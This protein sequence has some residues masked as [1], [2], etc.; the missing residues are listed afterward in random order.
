MKKLLI[1]FL[2]ITSI[3]LPI[4]PAIAAPIDPD[5]EDERLRY[6]TMTAAGDWDPAISPGYFVT[7]STYVPNCMQTL[8]QADGNWDRDM[9]KVGAGLLPENTRWKNWHPVLATNWT[10][11]YWPE[12]RNAIGIVNRGGV[13]SVTYTLREGVKFH[14]GSDWNATVAK[15]NLDRLLIISG[16]LSGRGDTR[17]KDNYW[18]KETDWEDMYT[19]SWNMSNRY[20]DVGWYFDGTTNWTNP[21]ETEVQGKFPHFET[22]IIE[23]KQSGGKIKIT[24]NLWNHYVTTNTGLLQYM[25]MH[26][27]KD[28]Y[29]T[30]IYGWGGDWNTGVGG[31]PPMMVGTGPFKY[32]GHS[33][34]TSPAGGTLIKN[35][36][37]W[38]KTALEDRG[39]FDLEY[40]DVLSWP[41]DQLGIESRNTAMLTHSVDLALDLF[42]WPLDYTDMINEPNINYYEYLEPIDYIT[43]LTL[44]CINET[45][46]SYTAND[47]RNPTGFNY[48]HGGVASIESI[49][50]DRPDGV[51]RALRKAMAYAF[52]YDTY[53]SVVMEGRAVRAGGVIGKG[54]IYYNDTLTLPEYNLTYA[55]QVLLNAEPDVFTWRQVANFSALCAARGL[56]ELSTNADWQWVADN[57]PLFELNLYWDDFFTPLKNLLQTNLRDI[58]IALT[59]PSGTTNFIPT[60]MWDKVSTYWLGTFPVW[61]AHAWPL[62]WNIPA[63]ICE[64]WIEANYYDPNDG[65]WRLN[66]WAPLIDPT[67]EWFPW[68]NLHFSYD[69]DIDNWLNRVFTSNTSTIAKML[70]K[71]ADK[72]QNEL[73]SML[74]IAQHKTGLAYWNEWEWGNWT[75]SFSFSRIRKIAPPAGEPIS[76][77]PMIVTVSVSAIALLST[78]YVMMR[79][80]K[81]K[82]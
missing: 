57:D 35:D 51:P 31:G 67:W 18:T 63:T 76:S 58:G 5:G 21:A 69:T 49:F 33:E 10:V 73:Y 79:R 74:Y 72:C 29:D 66:P 27:Y 7:S 11:E 13:K 24:W 25:S 68:F 14:D 32:G 6:A 53:I 22:E 78:I 4:I 50:G 1:C 56:T 26:T 16:N 20:N 75:G 54:N 9:R 38:N 15:W 47:P 23:S 17:N 8:T 45:W 44:N 3:A 39:W 64:G 30:G 12:E 36:D 82:Y 34:L 2:I 42:Q 40:V 60:Y 52:D 46:M 71:I 28:Y 81:I 61:S 19:P 55:R 77:F 59:D 62:D 48:V 65:D 37:Y 70:S 41:V 80:K 43:D